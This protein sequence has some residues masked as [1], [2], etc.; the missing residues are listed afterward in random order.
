MRKGAQHISSE[1]SNKK[2]GDDK[3]LQQTVN[4]QITCLYA[5]HPLWSVINISR[6]RRLTYAADWKNKLFSCILKTYKQIESIKTPTTST[7]HRLA[8]S[9]SEIYIYA[10]QVKTQESKPIR[11]FVAFICAV[12]DN[13]VQ[14]SHIAS[15]GSGGVFFGYALA[16]LAVFRW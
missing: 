4:M 14:Q 2:P 8:H 3:T 13:L 10:A 1:R 12:E 6:L 15:F 9:I 16:R 7:S 5:L 11:N